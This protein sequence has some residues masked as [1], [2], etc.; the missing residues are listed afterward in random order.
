MEQPT[1]NQQ[2]NERGYFYNLRQKDGFFK[3][4]RNRSWTIDSTVNN[5]PKPS[6][7]DSN[8]LITI[9][10][11]SQCFA[12]F[13]TLILYVFTLSFPSFWLALLSSITSFLSMCFSMFALF[14]RHRWTPWLVTPELLLTIAWVVL[15]VSSS[16][17]TPT[18]GKYETFHLGMI[19]IEASTVLWIQTC[20]L[21]VTPYFHRLAP[22]LFGV[23][24]E[25]NTGSNRS[26][27]DGCVVDYDTGHASS[28]PWWDSIP[29]SFP[30]AYCEPTADLCEN[31]V[32][33]GVEGPP[34]SSKGCG[35]QGRA[36]K[37]EDYDT[38]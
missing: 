20:L 31:G 32:P 3:N 36:S 7:Y 28:T 15:L 33:Y 2:G 23:Q 27:N 11:S 29:I 1:S 26:M 30:T 16:V 10:R 25:S 19:A 34:R 21:M 18:D 37:P 17:S 35:S 12:A 8:S 38:T 14:L 13:M 22:R 4:P 5:K 24:T 9:L 6:G